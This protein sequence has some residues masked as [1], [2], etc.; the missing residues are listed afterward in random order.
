MKL[1]TLGKLGLQ[2]SSFKRKKPLLLLTYLSLEGEQTRDYLSE[3]F[4]QGGSSRQRHNN[5]SRTLSDLRVHLPG[6]FDGDETKVWSSICTDVAEFRQALEA[7]QY[8][9]AADAYTGSFFEGHLSGWSTELEEWLFDKRTRLAEEAQDAFLMLAEQTFAHA[10]ERA[11]QYARSAL[12]LAEPPVEMLGRFYTLFAQ[13]KNLAREVKDLA[14]GY[15]L[16]LG[17][18]KVSQLS[19]GYIERDSP[20]QDLEQLGNSR[21]HSETPSRPS[22]HNLPAKGTSF[23]GREVELSNIT[24]GLSQPNCRLLSL[25]GIGG[26]GK[27]RLSIQAAHELREGKFFLDGVYYVRLDALTTADLIPS[28]IADAMGARLS[29][30]D[31][32]INQL[33][34]LI[35]AQATLLVL[36]NFEH[37]IEG[38]MLLPRLLQDCPNLK[39]IV[40]SRERLRLEEEWVFPVEGLTLP[41]DLTSKDI[42][43][44]DAVQLFV[45]RAIQAQFNFA[46]TP[47][48]STHV[49]KLCRLVEGSP[50]ALE[51]AAVWTK[52]IPID[53]LTQDIEANLDTLNANL[54]NRSERH[55]SLRAVFEH[56]WGLL[57]SA[58]QD[59]LGRLAVFRGGFTKE[60][61]VEVAGASL[62]VLTSLVDKSLLRV[63]H[64]GRYASHPLVFQYAQ[65]RLEADT[66]SLTRLQD[67][68]FS[69]F[70]ALA[71]K[72]APLL[73]GSEQKLWLEQLEQEHDNFRT[74]LRYA[75]TCDTPEQ[76]LSLSGKLMSLWMVRGYFSEGRS[77]LDKALSKPGSSTA[78]VR[79]RAL[80][81]AGWL[82]MEQGDYRVGHG[83]LVEGLAIYRDLNQPVDVAHSLNVLAGIAFCRK[84]YS[85]S[86]TY[87]EETL[88]IYQAIGER[89]GVAATLTNLGNVVIEQGRLK[90]AYSLC[91]KSLKINQELGNERGVACSLVRLGEIGVALGNHNLARK[92]LQQGLTVSKELDYK[93]F[94]A[95]AHEQ[96][97]HLALKENSYGR[98]QANY[99]QSLALFQAL[100]EQACITHVL[101]DFAH[102]AA[103][104]RDWQR[105]ACLVGTAESRWKAIGTSRTRSKQAAFEQ[106]SN[107]L[108]TQ[109]N[110]DTFCAIKD[111]GRRMTLE[112]AVAYALEPISDEAL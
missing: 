110:E 98:A 45:Q 79:A 68:H 104:Q 102:L 97:G 7:G 82:A 94:I 3:L 43:Q 73:Y 20:G 49:L 30:Q 88:A 33:A 105:S 93:I 51:L 8:E 74:A 40:T 17:P 28:T 18:E 4:W 76:A 24:Y 53:M 100:G 32:H 26:V 47:G 65:E 19:Q 90:E 111:E 38:A 78:Q 14:R 59:V 87:L 36:D 35:G 42:S 58:E 70:L 108:T 11:A 48:T 75:L 15:G 112:Q 22:P 13:D 84:D 109:L 77:W 27:S 56:S 41:N 62:D 72:A 29:G 10:P 55:R 50:L 64:S 95:V 34:H 2:G 96:L 52:V 21:Q 1:V 99:A 5:L 86:K 46:L 91:E 37:L 101:E 6:S 81:G 80:K 23:V 85:L 92:S 54:R 69:Y 25:V 39:I 57:N 71:E 67:R 83:Y 107:E 63:Q 60:A 44:F 61:A 16:S 66:A 12:R 103:R 106:M 89:V 9:R 31:S